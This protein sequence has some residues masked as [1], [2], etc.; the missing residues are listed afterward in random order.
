[1]KTIP[2]IL[3]LAAI[4]L[5]GGCSSPESVVDLQGKGSKAI[6]YASYDRVW[7]AAVAA[8]QTDQL[9]ILKAN[10][11][12]GYISVKRGWRPTTWG[13]NVGIWVRSKAPDQTEVEVV[14]RQA[15][16]PVLILSNWEKPLLHSIATNIPTASASL[17]LDQ[18]R[19]EPL[20]S[21][22]LTT[23]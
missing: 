4:M 2:W 22:K 15:G 17:G 8:S 19:K 10:K 3:G 6:Y 16:P 23:N 14:S 1:M 13:E 18:M 9:Y 5:A 7:D 11:T 21:S 20:E 12:K